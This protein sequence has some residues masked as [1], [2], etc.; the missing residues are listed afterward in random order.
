MPKIYIENLKTSAVPKD[1]VQFRVDRQSPVGN[2]FIMHSETERNAV[3]DKYEAY[4]PQLLNKSEARHY[5]NDILG[6]LR[7]GKDVCLMCW[8]Y[9]ARCHAETIR[10]YLIAQFHTQKGGK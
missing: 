6:T 3:C 8:C 1:V 2:P 7:A 9:P 4:F 10:N 5:L